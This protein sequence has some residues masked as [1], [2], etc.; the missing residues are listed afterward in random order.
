MPKRVSLK[1]VDLDAAGQAAA[2]NALFPVGTFVSYTKLGRPGGSGVTTG[3]A[4][5]ESGRTV[6]AMVPV[7]EFGCPVPVSGLEVIRPR[8]VD[9][10]MVCRHPRNGH[11]V[12]YAALQGDHEWI[13]P[14]DRSLRHAEPTTAPDPYEPQPDREDRAAWTV[15]PM[16]DSGRPGLFGRI[17]AAARRAA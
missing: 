2:W 3:P 6:R 4:T 5:V 13:D 1:G 14:Y 11:G 12:R 16:P 10:C 17:A 15:Q 8:T 9:P 7:S